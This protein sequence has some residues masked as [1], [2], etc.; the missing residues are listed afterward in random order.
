MAENNSGSDVLEWLQVQKVRASS[1]PELL[2][3]SWLIECMSAG[4]PVAT[5][6]QHQL[7]VSVLVVI[8]TV[9]GLMVRNMG[10]RANRPGIS[11]HAPC[12]LGWASHL[13]FLSFSFLLYNMG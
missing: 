7:I 9:L 3:V 12:G 10:N 4:K 1:Q 8:S 6:G 2:D 13:A 11:A 5:T